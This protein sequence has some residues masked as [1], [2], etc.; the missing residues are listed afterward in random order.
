M[1]KPDLISWTQSRLG[2]L[3]E[4]FED[5]S[6][7]SAFENAFSPSC[8]VRVNHTPSTLDTFKDSVSSRRAASTGITLSWENVITTG[9][10][11]DEP[12]V[13]SGTLIITRSMRFR[14]RAAPAQRQTHINFSAR[15]EIQQVQ[16]DEDDPLRITSLYHTSVDKSPP[17]HF[18][19]P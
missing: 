13:I 10:S 9:D 16:G 17:I 12:P 19:M 1:S 8:E 3:Y 2:A 11:L 5:E 15:V 14:I 4:A 7:A 18:A 6:F